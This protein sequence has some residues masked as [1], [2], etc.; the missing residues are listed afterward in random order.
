MN[1]ICL[2]S[3]SLFV[4]RGFTFDGIISLTDI[5]GKPFLISK[6]DEIIFGIKKS[7][8]AGGE[9]DDNE[10]TITLNC[11]DEIMGEY[12]FKLTPEKTSVLSGKYYY[13]VSVNF[14]D[15]DQ[16]QAVPYSV[17]HADMTA[18]LDYSPHNNK[19]TGTIP[20]KTSCCRTDG[21]TCGGGSECSCISNLTKGEI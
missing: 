21:K 17:L 11:D 14:A 10:L 20:R 5:Q 8:K 7:L 12:P 9:N 18:A 15:G 6:G 16:Y 4:Y 3:K 13:Y 2:H 19:I 1:D